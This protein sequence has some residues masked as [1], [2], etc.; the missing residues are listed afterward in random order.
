MPVD[1]DKY[2]NF[3]KRISE[4]LFI[5]TI[6]LTDWRKIFQYIKFVFIFEGSQSLEL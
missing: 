6:Q 5:L 1:K 4:S 3:L 2:Y